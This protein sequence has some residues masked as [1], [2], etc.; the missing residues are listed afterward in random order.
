MVMSNEQGRRR[1]LLAVA[2]AFAVSGCASM[3]PPA[4]P[5]PLTG[6]LWT[7]QELTSMPVPA[8]EAGVGPT[9]QIEAAERRVTGSTGVNRYMGSAT[10]DAGALSFSAIA[11]S[12]RAGP[13]PAMAVE[14]SLLKALEATRAYRISGTQLDLLDGGGALLARFA[15]S[16]R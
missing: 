9:L 2:L 7:L 11:S 10:F 14:R 1:C 12:R 5:L 13:L 3:N 8:N 16:A 4:T 15:G 6:T